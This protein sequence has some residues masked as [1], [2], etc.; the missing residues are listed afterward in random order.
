M[1]AGIRLG[2]RLTGRRV[3]KASAPWLQ[4]PMGRAGRIGA[5]FYD[6]LATAREP[7]HPAVAGRGV[8]SLP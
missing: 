8:A 5:E 1:E 2:I 3:A 4:C 7:V 6:Q